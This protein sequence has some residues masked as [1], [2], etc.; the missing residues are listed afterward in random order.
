MIG[1]DGREEVEY[2]YTRPLL[3][4]Q[5]QDY[6]TGSTHHAPFNILKEDIP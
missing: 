1:K 2:T 5:P 3:T 6:R 4:C